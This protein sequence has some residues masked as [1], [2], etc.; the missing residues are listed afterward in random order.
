[1]MFASRRSPKPSRSRNE[2]GF[3]IVAVLWILAALATLASIYSIYIDNSAAASH[4]NDDRLRAE[5][6]VQAAL[7]LTAYQLSLT[8]PEARPTFG[9]FAFR[10]GQ[11]AVRV[12][13]QSEGARIDL[14]VAPKELIAGLFTSFGAGPEQAN[15]YADHI[16]AWRTKGEAAGENKEA[17]AYKT[18]ALGYAPRQAPF[19]NVLELRLVREIPARFVDAVLP[20]VTVFNGRA[21]IDVTTASPDVLSALPGMTPTILNQVLAQRNGD[22]ANGPAMLER[23]GAARAGAGLDPRNANRVAVAVTLP[24]GRSMRAEA[25]IL[26]IESGEEPY[27]VLSWSDDFDS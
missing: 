8:N 13:F 20:Y 6:A 3:I 9:S 12:G 23:L 1:M 7:E 5:A 27:K 26:M 4:V 22:P 2:R 15:A 19:A 11:T 18:D 21:D 25:V 14:N 16:V 17:D 10:L 24:N